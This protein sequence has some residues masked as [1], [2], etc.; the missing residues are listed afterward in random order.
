LA[1]KLRLITARLS[2]ADRNYYRIITKEQSGAEGTHVLDGVHVLLG[3]HV[4]L[5]GAD[6]VFEG[7][8]GGFGPLDAVDV[9]VIGSMERRSWEAE[10]SRS[11]HFVRTRGSGTRLHHPCP[12]PKSV[13]N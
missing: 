9:I 8:T 10:E 7:D 3:N 4:A 12:S 11:S 6:G 5:A 1:T 13:A 2:A